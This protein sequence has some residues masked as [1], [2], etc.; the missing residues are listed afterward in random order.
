MGAEAQLIRASAADP[1]AAPLL[2]GLQEE[3][4]RRYDEG[5]T[6][7]HAYGPEEFSPP[8]GVFLL[9]VEGGATL[10]GGAVRRYDDGIGELKRMWTAPAARRRGHGRRILAA[11]ED[12]ARDLGYARVRLETGTEQPEAVAMYERA[13]YARIEPYG[14][15]RRD[16]R[17][18]CFEK[19]L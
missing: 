12:A 1:A 3:Y 18:I 17:T 8:G 15:Y 9:L 19:A 11:L 13:G 14:R 2:D 16:P 4:A 5:S 10:A 6:E 7:M